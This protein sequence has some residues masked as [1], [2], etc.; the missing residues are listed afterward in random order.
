VLYA[1]TKGAAA[2]GP[3]QDAWRRSMTCALLSE[4]GRN[5][6]ALE[7]DYDAVGSHWLTP[8]EFPPERRYVDGRWTT[9][10]YFGGNFWLASASFLR[11]LPEPPL[12]SRHD[13]EAWIGR[14]PRPPRALN[15]VPGWPL[16]RV[17]RRPGWPPDGSR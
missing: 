2:P 10:P 17:C 13:A 9:T 12:E 6:E 11:A 16:E 1:H 15:L 14:G 5:L 4:L 7:A 8:E 3:H